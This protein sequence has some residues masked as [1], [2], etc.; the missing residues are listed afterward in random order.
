MTLSREEKEL[1][2]QKKREAKRIAQEQRERSNQSFFQT[3]LESNTKSGTAFVVGNGT[4]RSLIDIHAL[5]NHGVVFGCNG[6]YRQHRPDYLIAVD[7]KMILEINREGYNV[8]NEVWTNYNK[9]YEKLK[10]L[11]YFKPSKGW[12]SGPTALHMSTEKGF[13]TIYILGFDYKGLQDGRKFNNMYADTN[14][15]KRSSD[16]A[17]YYGNWLKQTK[18]VIEQNPAVQYVRVVDH[19]TFM[20]PE[21]SNLTNLRTMKKEAFIHLFN[22]KL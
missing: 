12:S 22:N 10:N 13:K 2:K 8:H 1:K 19:D 11:N 14:N 3:K 21:L 6:L 9:A 18:T 4:S 17:T 20:P 7:V 15:Y 16:G 5:H